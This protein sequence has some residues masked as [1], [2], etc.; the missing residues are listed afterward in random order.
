M[1][2]VYAFVKIRGRSMTVDESIVS[3]QV[4]SSLLLDVDAVG[5]E[6]SGV[7]ASDEFDTFDSVLTP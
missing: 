7:F 3:G 5:A 1:Y 2:F 6:E 4:L